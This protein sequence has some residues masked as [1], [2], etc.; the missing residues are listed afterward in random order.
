MFEGLKKMGFTEAPAVGVEL[1]TAVDS[2]DQNK[3]IKA[4]HDAIYDRFAKMS[5]VIPALKTFLPHEDPFVRFQAANALYTVGDKS[6]YQTLLDLVRAP[7]P[8]GEGNQ[9][10]RAQAA[11]VLGKY[12]EHRAG[13]DLLELLRRAQGGKMRISEVFANLGI[14]SPEATQRSFLSAPYAFQHYGQK[15]RVD[16]IPQLKATF[17]DP[18]L[19]RPDLKGAAAWALA[20]MT[21][22]EQ[23][24]KYLIQTAQPAIKGRLKA[25]WSEFDEHAK[26]VRYLGS[27]QQPR[28]KETLEQALDSPNQQVVTY[29]VVNLIFNQGG[30]ENAVDFLL[31]ELRGESHVLQLPILF[32]VAAKVP[33]PRIQEAG[34]ENDLRTASG[35]WRYYGVERKDWPIYGWIDD[36]V[37]KLNP[38][39]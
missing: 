27:I 30:S 23:Y 11:S 34:R 39:K 14:Y 7:D 26:A 18:G 29:A 38:P 25:E 8:L 31:R 17:Q 16:V 33:D 21:G 20:T 6:G 37:A 35:L 19:R 5:D 13:D 4:F 3:I 28:A 15:H 32:Q 10:A 36:Y 9:D 2:G 1:R 24:V 22:E 12:R